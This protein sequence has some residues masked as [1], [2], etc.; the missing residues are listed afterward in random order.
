MGGWRRGHRDISGCVSRS[1]VCPDAPFPR[2]PPHAQRI[3]RGQGRSGTPVE[4]IRCDRHGR[5]R[6]RRAGRAPRPP[7]LRRDPPR[8]SVGGASKICD[9]TRLF[10]PLR[11]ATKCSSRSRR[12]DSPNP[13]KR[14]I[15]RSSGCGDSTP[16]VHQFPVARSTTAPPKRTQR[17]R[18][19]PSRL[20]L[21]LRPY[22]PLAP[23][24]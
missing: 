4:I 18:P 22:L 14:I 17:S 1:D 12:P 8:S 11:R 9:R 7:G 13:L 5:S 10:Q 23:A 21:F 15:F 19:N 2:G 20:L 24:T 3:R 16:S 6:C